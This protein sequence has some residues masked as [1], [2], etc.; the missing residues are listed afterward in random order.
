MGGTLNLTPLSGGPACLCCDLTDLIHS[1]SQQKALGA[2][3]TPG[4]NGPI[5]DITNAGVGGWGRVAGG[6]TGNNCPWVRPRQGA[7]PTASIVTPR[8]RESGTGGWG[9]LPSAKKGNRAQSRPT[10]HNYSPTAGSDT[11]YQVLSGPEILWRTVIVAQCQLGIVRLQMLKGIY[12]I[13]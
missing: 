3:V 4:N 9:G 2:L 12:K 8:P 7:S 6:V 5:S 10:L 1:T 13:H 11:G